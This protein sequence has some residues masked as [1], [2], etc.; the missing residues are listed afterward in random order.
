M[1][2]SNRD[3]LNQ[4]LVIGGVYIPPGGSASWANIDKGTVGEV[5]R[6]VSTSI[7]LNNNQQEAVLT[8]TLYPEDEGYPLLRGLIA[9][10]KAAR[11]PLAGTRFPGA[12]VNLTPGA[13]NETTVWADCHLLTEPQWNASAEAEEVSATFGLIDWVSK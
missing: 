13:S 1:P 4:S 9:T 11:G 12:G 2:S 7:K 5:V 3:I 10:M 6:G 8:V